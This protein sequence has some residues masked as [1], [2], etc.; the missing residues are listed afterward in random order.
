MYDFLLKNLKD[1][2]GKILE[3]KLNKRKIDKWPVITQKS[4]QHNH[5]R[6]ANKSKRNIIVK[7]QN[8]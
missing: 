4:T 6:N 8:G 2:M 7:Y 3:W 1:K 5:Q